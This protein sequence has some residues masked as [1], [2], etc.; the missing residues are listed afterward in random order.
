M[1]IK[2]SGIFNIVQSPTTFI[3]YS[4]LSQSMPCEM[5]GKEASLV[6]ADVEGVNLRVCN[7][8]AKYGKVKNDFYAG[9]PETFRA[10]SGVTH[11]SLQQK[12]EFK[13]INNFFRQLKSVRNNRELSH[14]DFAK[15]L[16]EKQSLVAKWESGSAQP[17]I[18]A[19]RRVGRILNLNLVVKESQEEVEMPAMPKIKSDGLT[20]GDFIKVRRKA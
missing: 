15:L 7:N 12:T 1:V 5:C 6:A 8:C 2:Q 10:S 16:N 19:A 13:V 4:I 17:T 3:S 18:D 9:Q 11:S 20:L 14:E